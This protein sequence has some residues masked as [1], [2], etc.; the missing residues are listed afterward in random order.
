MKF[1]HKIAIY[2]PSTVYA[3]VPTDN[4]E[5]VSGLLKTLSEYFGGATAVPGK[6]AYVT[7]SG[8]LVTEDVTICYAF[9]E[10]A[11][12]KIA[13]DVAVEE[14]KRV[15]DQMRQECVMVEIDGVAHLI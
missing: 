9:V 6:G 10:R 14:A 15:R 8:E 3:H 4:S 7:D 5:I 12:V 1:E 11:K 2:V 13:T